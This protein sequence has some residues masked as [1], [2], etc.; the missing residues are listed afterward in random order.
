MDGTVAEGLLDEG[1]LAA[2]PV[3]F[4][5]TYKSEDTERERPAGPIASPVDDE[6]KAR[7]KSLGYIQ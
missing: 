7:L 4:Q 5:E 2:A 1:F 6:L 3:R